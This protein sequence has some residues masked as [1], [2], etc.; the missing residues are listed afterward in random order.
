MNGIPY[1]NHVHISGFVGNDPE[2]RFLPTGDPVMS[3]RIATKHFWKDA[4]GEWKTATEWHTAV[5]YRQLAHLAHSYGFKKGDF[6]DLEGRLHTREWVD[7]HQHKRASRE[8]IADRFHRVDLPVIQKHADPSEHQDL[9]E[10][11]TANHS[12]VQGPDALETFRKLT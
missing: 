1:K 8:V 5:F 2:I 7:D 10:A 9:E 11:S 12:E 4:G 3:L 6:I